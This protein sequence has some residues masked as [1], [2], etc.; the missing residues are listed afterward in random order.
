M[1][2]KRTSERGRIGESGRTREWKRRRRRERALEGCLAM[3]IM[4]SLGTN[5]F[6]SGR[7][8]STSP[9][10]D[11]LFY[12]EHKKK[13]VIVTGLCVSVRA[14]AVIRIFH[15]QVGPVASKRFY[16]RD[17]RINGKNGEKYARRENIYSANLNSTFS[18]AVTYTR[19][20]SVTY[21]RD[22]VSS[23]MCVTIFLV[24]SRSGEK[25]V[26]MQR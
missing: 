4:P 17:T 16:L 2:H 12:Y 1:L 15:E 3:R 6:R 23:C 9:P 26:N 20:T 24:I 7:S 25:R 14:I 10:S 11:W 19:R 22:F 5:K 13:Y 21:A 8:K 18:Q